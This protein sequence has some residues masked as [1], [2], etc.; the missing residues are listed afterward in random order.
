MRF[1]LRCFWFVVLLMGSVLSGWAAAP[2]SLGAALNPDGTL[3]SGVSG[4][5]DARHFALR[6][7]PDGRPAF[8]PAARQPARR[9]QGSGD[10][11]WSKDFALNGTN[12][13]VWAV[14]TDGNGKV[15]IGGGF[16]VA[17]GVP[18]LNI[19]L[20]DGQR[21]QALGN[22]LGSAYG[23]NSNTV[24]ALAL[25]HAGNLYAGGSFS[26]SGDN[27]MQGVAKWNG[28]AWSALGSGLGGSA[29][30]LAVDGQDNLYAGGYFTTAGGVPANHVA[31]WNGS[32]WSALGAGLVSTGSYFSPVNALAFDRAG[33]LY[34]GGGFDRAGGQPASDV[35]R[36][37]GTSWTA[38]G[39][40]LRGTVQALAVDASGTVYA[41]GGFYQPGNSYARYGVA[42]WSGS[43]WAE[44][45]YSTS[46]VW[47]LAVDNAGAV[48]AGG[49]FSSV[50]RWSGT[51][52]ATLGS[53]R[54]ESFT[55]TLALA[56]APNGT[57]YAG[58]HLHQV[59]GVVANGIAQWTPA[60][61]S[62]SRLNSLTPALAPNETVLALLP[63]PGGGV[64]AAGNFDALG[65]TV[66]TAIAKWTGTAWTRL[67]R[68]LGRVSLNSL[69]LDGRGNLYAGG[70]LSTYGLTGCG[71]MRW[72][73]SS[74]TSVGGT[75]FNEVNAV[76]A[77]SAT[78]TVYLAGR[79]FIGQNNY[80]HVLRW[81][82]TSW[83]RMGA[84][85]DGA[86]RNLV[87]ARDGTL[88][89]GGDFSP[90]TSP[91]TGANVARWTGTAWQ[92]IPTGTPA[93][94]N[95]LAVRGRTVYA[96][97]ADGVARWD[98]TVW[99]FI[100]RLPGTFVPYT[101]ALDST[102]TPYVGGD[103]GQS[104]ANVYK[105][106]GAAWIAV[107]GGTNAAVGA[108]AAVGDGLYAGG[109]FS[110]SGDGSVPMVNFGY[111]AHARQLAGSP[112]AGGGAAAMAL[113]PNPAHD[114]LTV[115]YAASPTAQTLL[116]TDALG[117][118]VRRYPVP[119]GT[120][121][122]TLDVLGV[123]PGLYVLRGAD[124]NTRK[125]VVE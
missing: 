54:V 17:G 100:G 44:V 87:V 34:V 7:A 50:L 2:A 41:G 103:G 90:A 27:Y 16:T 83:Q 117:R 91:G 3:R 79:L 69:A 6:T 118:T 53:G 59:G 75:I 57:L 122:A 43:T 110:A 8:G 70:Y 86:V 63:A 56:V 102:G 31:K 37:D 93:A 22:G 24:T 51:A 15:Y 108:L 35:A 21:W 72:D 26:S 107:G 94:V 125:L 29:T 98:G 47:S 97:S 30:S 105:W 39:T 101:M 74:W 60:T 25:D 112:G 36:W 42:R 66:A 58:G 18:V 78:G 111:F 28:T 113:Y 115:Q 80:A 13:S 19:A 82:G 73:G 48:Y 71:V 65:D 104:Q 12:G 123:T 116:L 119:A 1:A 49:M 120:A 92:P 14:A 64:Y 85:L 81:S 38:L 106:N 45:G 88:Y 84:D 4:S 77:D 124:G 61:G 76:A 11:G 52:W 95:A 23:S 46:D 68:G 96:A 109:S 5:F 33:N 121:E 20:W 32:T 10:D 67:G 99:S 62:W 89:A 55:N 114:Y 40:N 9:T